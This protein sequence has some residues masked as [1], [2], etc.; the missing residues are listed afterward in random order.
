MRNTPGRPVSVSESVINAARE[1]AGAKDL[2]KDSC[3]SADE[4][5]AL[6]DVFQRQEK[7]RLGRNPLAMLPPLS[8]STRRK[9]ARRVAPIVVRNGGVQNTSRF[10]ALFDG[11]NAISCAATWPAVTQ[12]ITNPKLIHS[13]DECAVKLNPFN[14]KQAVHCSQEG[15]ELLEEQNLIPATTETQPQRRMLKIGP[16][17][18]TM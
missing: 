8:S 13:W 3:T 14:E 15:R 5:M 9:I 11:R 16:S 2:R 18:F 17:K 7:T 6:V 1:E 10:K 4:V 12:G